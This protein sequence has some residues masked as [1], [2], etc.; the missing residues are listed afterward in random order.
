MS[1]NYRFKLYKTTQ[2]M[3]KSIDAINILPISTIVFEN[4]ESVQNMRINEAIYG[5]LGTLAL[6]QEIDINNG[7]IKAKTVNSREMEFMP[8]APVSFIVRNW[9]Q[10]R[11]NSFYYSPRREC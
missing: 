7:E 5:P 6:I 8:P 2:D 11:R 4:G 1:E 10:C 9:I 3:D